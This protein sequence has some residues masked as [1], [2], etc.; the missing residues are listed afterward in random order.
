MVAYLYDPESGV[1]LDMNSVRAYALTTGTG[2]TRKALQVAVGTS[3]Y[4]MQEFGTLQGTPCRT[5]LTVAGPNPSRGE[6][7]V[8]YTLANPELNVAVIVYNGKGKLVCILESTSR[9]AGY[10]TLYWNCMDNTG[11][12]VLPGIY[13]IVL[14][15][16]ADTEVRSLIFVK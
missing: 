11:K 5:N 10:Y 2:L 6:V 16:T 3:E 13:H 14:Q 7:K 1:T 9:S 12:N 4:I 8:R 15:T